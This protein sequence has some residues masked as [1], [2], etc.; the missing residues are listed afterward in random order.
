MP[1]ICHCGYPPSG[2]PISAY[3]RFQSCPATHFFLQYA[4]FMPI[5][6]RYARHMPHICL[7][8]A[9]YMPHMCPIPDVL[10]LRHRGRHIIL[11][12]NYA[13]KPTF[14]HMPHICQ[15]YAKPP[16]GLRQKYAKSPPHGWG[17]CQAYTDQTK[18]DVKR[19]PII[20]QAY[21]NEPR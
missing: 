18:K 10:P 2:G 20:C 13:Y 6:P 1:G 4:A 11:S 3:F 9:S 7:I 21:A 5:L 16:P 17:I 15:A 14:W 8:Y 12:I 19:R